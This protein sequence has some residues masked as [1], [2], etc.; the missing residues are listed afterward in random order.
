MAHHP[1]N[2]HKV[3]N[4]H[5]NQRNQCRLDKRI[6]IPY[7]LVSRKAVAVI[8]HRNHN[9]FEHRISENVSDQR[10]D[11]RHND[12]HRQIM[13]HQFPARVTRSAK[14]SDGSRLPS[15]RVADCNGKNK[16][17]NHN[18][19]RAAHRPSP[20]QSPCHPLQNEWQGSHI[21]EHNPQSPHPRQPPASA[22]LS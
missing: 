5:Q 20:H 6:R 16:S 2:H 8:I 19:N 3:H 7:R 18:Q 9:I 11:E 1:R 22:G 17:N 10:R 21:P 13:C 4:K 15:N 12:R 14:C